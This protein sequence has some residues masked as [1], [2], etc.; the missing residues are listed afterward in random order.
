[1][2]KEPLISVI[3]PTYNSSET[4]IACMDSVLSQSVRDIEV[5]VVDGGSE[6]DTVEKVRRCEDED[7][8]V[9]LVISDEKGVSHQRNLGIRHAKGDY[10]QFTDSD[11]VI[12][13]FGLKLLSDAAAEHDA[14][15]VIAGYEFM[16]SREKRIPKA[17]SFEDRKSFVQRIDD[18]YAPERLFLNSPCN[19]LYKKS[20]VREAFPRDMEM[21]EDLVFNIDAFM[22]AERVCVIDEPVY[23]VNDTNSDSLSRRFRAEGFS[24]ETR[25]HRKMMAYV[26]S[27]TG[28]IPDY[29]YYSYLSGV[30][31]KLD[32]LVN[33]SGWSSED[34]KREIYRWCGSET[35][36]D[37]LLKYRPDRFKDRLLVRLLDKKRVVIIYFY[38]RFL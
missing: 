28:D 8:R 1:M 32:H 2:N 15:I 21:G 22:R 9:R 17:G 6:D 37:M 26:S 31:V 38:Y 33:K 12:M 10:I 36:R 3:I 16:K 5:I 35:L 27:I 18:Y 14:D 20:I 23:L 19:K 25:L 7:N 29:L 24:C 11:D 4:I 30:K 13:P 34:I